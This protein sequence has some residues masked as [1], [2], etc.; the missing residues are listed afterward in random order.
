MIDYENLG[1]LNQ[2]FFQEYEKSF[3]KVMES[4]W[5]ILGK[6]VSEF[7]TAFASGKESWLAIK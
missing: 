6:H 1:R 4:G 3:K 7:E 2:P 5:Y